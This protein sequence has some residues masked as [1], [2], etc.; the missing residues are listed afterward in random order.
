MF[1][2]FG[3][4]RSQQERNVWL[5]LQ[6]QGKSP[7]ILRY[8]ALFTGLFFLLGCLVYRLAWH[9]TGHAT[10][11]LVPILALTL[12]MGYMGSEL[13]WSRGVRLTRNAP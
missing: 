1:D 7:F 12:A 3:S 11:V 13:A 5:Q 8:T 9:G 4:I 6:R 2:S 10:V